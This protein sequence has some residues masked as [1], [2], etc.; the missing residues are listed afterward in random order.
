MR[1]N[2]SHNFNHVSKTSTESE[3]FKLE[4]SDNLGMMLVSVPLNG[5]NWLSWSRA[6]C[7][8]LGAKSKFGFL[9][10]ECVK[11]WIKADCMVASCIL[12]TISKDIVQAYM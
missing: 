11:P 1:I 9:T 10:G 7:R 2:S 4:V 5:T 6:V 8:S 12:S 3:V